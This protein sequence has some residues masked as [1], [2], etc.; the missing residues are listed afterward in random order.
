MINFPSMSRPIRKT[1]YT[2]NIDN[3]APEICAL[4]YPLMKNYARKIGAAFSII[5]ERKFPEWPVV[6]EKLQIHE[7]AKGEYARHADVDVLE[8]R[9]PDDWQIF[10]DSD[11]LIS[12]EFFDVT[13]LLSKDTV[14]HNG[15]DMA[16]L[17]F[18]KNE[19][20]LP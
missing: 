16:G 17:R 8:P 4:T 19:K 15:R 20:F 14:L 12:P 9:E 10:V 13:E 7:L 1:L 3:Y 2:L 6:Y 5:D 11:A 18:K